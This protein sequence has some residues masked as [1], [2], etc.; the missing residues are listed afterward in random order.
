ML[1]AWGK[2]ESGILQGNLR[3]EGR[4]FQCRS[5]E[6]VVDSKLKFA[7]KWCM[8]DIMASNVSPNIT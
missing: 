1:D 2:P 4:Y 3:W 7:G 8:A 5:V 6:N